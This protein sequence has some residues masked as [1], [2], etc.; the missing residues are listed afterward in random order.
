MVL[1]ILEATFITS[2]QCDVNTSAT[3]I[4][5]YCGEEVSLSAFGVSYSQSVLN[6]D[7]NAS[8]FGPG[9]ASTSGATS[10]ANPCSPGGTDGTPHAWMDDN[11]SVPRILESA[12]YD[13]S[14]ATAG[15]TI[16]FDLLFAEQGGN[17]PSVG[18]NGLVN[19]DG[20]EVTEG[21]YFYTYRIVGENVEDVRE[22]RGNV[23]LMCN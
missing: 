11:T 20:A 4:Q 17:A 22:G 10:F 5:I 13:F 16:C 9:W 19:N 7:F 18:W 3:K 2:A 1:P 14:T 21:V 23:H 8:G 6:E 12:S 15:V